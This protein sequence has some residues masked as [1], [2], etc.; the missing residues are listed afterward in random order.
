[1]NFQTI[2]TFINIFVMGA[3]GIGFVYNK[4]DA[5]KFDP[6]PIQRDIAGVKTENAVQANDIIT[7]KADVKEIKMDVKEILKTL[8]PNDYKPAVSEKVKKAPLVKGVEKNG[9][10]INANE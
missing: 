2:I 3:A 10:P 4:T 1:M 6:A 5:A 8:R 9:E 7:L